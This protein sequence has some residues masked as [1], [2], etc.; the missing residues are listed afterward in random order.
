MNPGGW[1]ALLRLQQRDAWKR[2]QWERQLYQMAAERR[3][4]ELL[5][6]T[7]AAS[8]V[9]RDAAR[10][11]A[12]V[13]GL[14]PYTGPLTRVEALGVPQVGPEE[15]A[16]IAQRRSDDPRGPSLLVVGGNEEAAEQVVQFVLEQRGGLLREFKVEDFRLRTDLAQVVVKLNVD[17]VL[18]IPAL[19]PMPHEM[20]GQLATLLEHGFV[21]LEKE[22]GG[23]TKIV[24]IKL[25][26]CF[27]TSWSTTGRVPAPLTGWGA[28]AT[29]PSD[30]KV[31]P[32]CAEEVKAAALL[33]RYC[34]YEFGPLPLPGQPGTGTSVEEFGASVDKLADEEAD[35]L[36]P[37]A[38]A[39]IREYDRV[40][41][42]LLQQ[43]LK[44]GHARAARIVDQ[45]TA[46]GYIG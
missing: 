38:I 9:A 7:R 5:A 27:I 29:M 43:R 20:V 39:V 40:S 15:L 25:P 14:T 13:A 42:S 24:E 34:R 26:P 30:T 16:A 4:S 1:A 17:D 37:D 19:T 45:L 44:I 46:L 18:F 32:Q 35:R 21:Q 11:T 36:L 31:C 12:P 8:A 22:E 23:A 41:A 33:C 3:H 6:A 28:M 2:E 10:E